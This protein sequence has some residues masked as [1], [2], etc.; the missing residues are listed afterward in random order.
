MF[1]QS[2]VRTFLHSEDGL[3]LLAIETICPLIE[4][5]TTVIIAPKIADGPQQKNRPTTDAHG[6]GGNVCQTVNMDT[7]LAKFCPRSRPRCCERRGRFFLTMVVPD[8]TI[9]VNKTFINRTGKG[10]IP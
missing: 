10:A 2:G 3:C 7:A 9:N 4:L 8:A 5:I 6:G 1:A